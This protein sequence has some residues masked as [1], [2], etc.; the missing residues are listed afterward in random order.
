MDFSL[1]CDF[2]FLNV[3]QHVTAKE[4]N[5]ENIVKKSALSHA[6]TV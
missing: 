3:D 5:E 6:A 2:W 1:K 4:F